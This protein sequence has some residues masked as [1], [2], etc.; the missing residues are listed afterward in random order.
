MNQAEEE[1][2]RRAERARRTALFRYE[3]IQDVIDPQLS[4]RER[5]RLVRGLAGREHD[6]PAG[7]R[8]R[9]SEQTIRRWARDWR[10][11]GFEALVPSPARVSP[12]TPAEVLELA[13]ALKREK[14]ARTAVQIT[15]I[16]RVQAGWAPSDRTLQRHFVRLEPG[17]ELPA[18]PQVHGRFEASRCNEIWTGDALHG[19]RIT[20]RKTYLFAFLDDRSRAVMA[21]RFGFS[22]DTVRLAAALRPALASRGVPAH[23]YVDNGSAFVD[24]WLLRACASLGIKLVHSQPGRPEGRGKIERFFRTV[25]E[26]FLVEIGD[27]SA[28][29]GLA[30][31]NRLFTA[32]VETVYHPRPHSETGAAPLRRWQEG[33]PVPLPLPTP[34][35]LREAFLWS[36]YRTVTKTA[37]VSLH[38]N[39]YQVDELL[40]GRKAELV[41]DP[42]NLEDIEVRYGGRSFGTAVAFTIG[43]HSHPRARPEQPGDQPP[44]ATG[45]DYLALLGTAHDNRQLRPRI[46][47][48]ALFGD[49]AGPAGGQPGDGEPG[50]GP[51]TST[52]AAGEG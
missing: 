24:S 7:G 49:D 21:A 31:L 41:F 16:L 23:V 10:C 35:Q 44:P 25:R 36:E 22:E 12:R 37:T 29:T 39:T 43:R 32:W 8:V 28:I 48:A 47:F 1:Q 9:V 4:A 40:A 17:R 3:L 2:R 30:E 15:R 38:G 33:I 14:P 51:G 50:T 6:G 13:V 19:P 45:I 11:G 46:N 18:A 52:R 26:Q 34:A 27:G 20:G 5:G 42:F